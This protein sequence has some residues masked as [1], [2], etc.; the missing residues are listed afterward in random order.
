MPNTRD[1]LLSA[2]AHRRRQLLGVAAWLLA[3]GV[4]M[5]A[6]GA[7]KMASARHMTLWELLDRLAQQTPFS[8]EKIEKLLGIVLVETANASNEFFQF[9]KL[10]SALTL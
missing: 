9:Y 1:H 3:G 8:R 6:L 2:L 10:P 4:P 7:D 5:Q